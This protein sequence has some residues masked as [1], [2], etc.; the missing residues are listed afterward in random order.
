MIQLVSQFR[1][2]Q[3]NN[4][5]IKFQSLYRGYITRK[6]TILPTPIIN[7]VLCNQINAFIKLGRRQVTDVTLEIK[8]DKKFFIKWD[9]N[10]EVL[11][12]VFPTENLVGSGFW[13]KFFSANTIKISLTTKKKEIKQF[14]SVRSHCTADT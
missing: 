9:K 11:S 12:L 1:P 6:Y 5:V 10:H 3:L 8:E 7:A 14:E 2:N 4:G 13:K